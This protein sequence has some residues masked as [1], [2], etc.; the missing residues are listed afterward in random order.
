MRLRRL[1]AVLL[2][3]LVAVH[4]AAVQPADGTA[5]IPAAAAAID[6]ARS[7]V[8]FTVTKLGFSD[9]DGTFRDFDVELRYDPDRPAL[10]SVRWRVRVAS[11]KTGEANRDRALQSVEYF[12]AVHHP[13]L[14]FE[15]RQVRALDAG[16]LEVEGDIT[17]KG[18]TRPLTI[19]VARTADGRF[20]TRFELDRYDFDVRG[21]RVMS[22]LIG[23]TVR[24]HLVATAEQEEA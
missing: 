14:T 20:E 19:I 16:R 15:S 10:S 11:V 7:H 3:A 8:G 5:R 9:V 4:S 18:R 22:R 13:E 2:F 23:R 6:P 17:I 24:I 1:P 12:D 21:G